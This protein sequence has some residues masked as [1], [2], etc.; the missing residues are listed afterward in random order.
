VLKSIIAFGVPT[1]R[2]FP[3]WIAVLRDDMEEMAPGEG[4]GPDRRRLYLTA[5]GAMLA[6]V[7]PLVVDLVRTNMN[8]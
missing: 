6:P 5:A 2:H 8:S 4:L 7:D 1:A 3:N